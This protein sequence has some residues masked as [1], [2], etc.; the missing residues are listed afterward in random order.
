MVVHS[1]CRE[2]VAHICGI[3]QEAVENYEKWK[4]QVTFS[5]DQRDRLIFIS[6]V[7]M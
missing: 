7:M 2:K 1:K 3:R 4:E 5:N 6:F